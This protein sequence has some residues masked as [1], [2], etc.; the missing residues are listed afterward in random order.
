[1]SAP[2]PAGAPGIPL[3]RRVLEQ[4]SRQGTVSGQSL[5]EALGVTRAAVWKA[6]QA[7][8]AQGYPVES[9]GGRGYRLP[10]GLE[11]LDAA[12]LQASLPGELACPVE[13]V[14]VTGSTN[15][16]LLGRLNEPLPRAL[17]AERQ[18]CG[19]GRWGRHWESDPGSGIYFSLAWPFE[20]AAGG[21]AALSL[22]TALHLAEVLEAWGVPELGLK[23]PN[24]LL[25]GEAKLGGILVEL[26]GEIPG[27]C[28]AVVGVGVNW[29]AGEALAG[30]AGRAVAG[31]ADAAPA[32]PGRGRQA[33]AAELLA[34]TA[35]ACRSV[36]QGSAGQQLRDG[37]P[38]YDRLRDRPVT[39]TLPRGELQG[40]ARGIDPDGALRLET[41]EGVTRLWSGEPE[42]RVRA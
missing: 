7:L 28:R 23:W 3:T 1:M 36:E 13:A 9:L 38:R 35:R 39:V 34:A 17:F 14:E 40:V 5:G 10:G 32:A 29:R 15:A 21:L 24:D 19:R 4:L 20:A 6:V 2:Q 26:A 22:V 16:D 31:V 25:R 37:W 27:P 42:L 11:P 8:R 30:R 41:A 12:A 18:R 33:L